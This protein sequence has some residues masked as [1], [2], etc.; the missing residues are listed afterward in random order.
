MLRVVATGRASVA[1]VAAAARPVVRQ[2]PLFSGR[3]GAGYGARFIVS[4]AA[5]VGSFACEGPGSTRASSSRG[6]ASQAAAND[7]S[8]ED[9][10]FQAAAAALAQF[11]NKLDAE[12]TGQVPFSVLEVGLDTLS[13]R[14]PG[15]HTV[16]VALRQRLA[17]HEGASVARAEWDS[18][19]SE[20]LL[21]RGQLPSSLRVDASVAGAVPPSPSSEVVG[22]QRTWSV[23]LPDLRRAVENLDQDKVL[24][25]VKQRELFGNSLTLADL[26]VSSRWNAAGEDIAAEEGQPLTR[27]FVERE[28]RRLLL[29]FFKNMDL[30]AD[31]WVPHGD[32]EAGL[33]ALFSRAPSYFELTS[34]LLQAIGGDVDQGVHADEWVRACDIAVE[35]ILNTLPTDWET[36]VSDMMQELEKAI[37]ALDQTRVRRKAKRRMILGRSLDVPS[38]GEEEFPKQRIE[39]VSSQQL[40]GAG[41][42]RFESCLEGYS[43]VDATLGSGAFARVFLV[44]NEKTGD[45]QA[46]KRIDRQAMQK[47]CGLSKEDVLTRIEHEFRHLQHTDHPHIIKLLEFG[48]DSRYSYFVMEAANGGDLAKVADHAYG[49]VQHKKPKPS[50]GAEA[51]PA[52]PPRKLSEA[53]VAL[54]LEQTVYALHDLHKEGRIHK[55]LK[56]EN[57]MLRTRELPPHVVL[58]DLGFMEMLPEETGERLMPAGTPHTMAP[59]VIE[60][61]LGQRPSFDERCDIYSLGVVLFELL[62]GRPPYEPAYTGPRGPRQEV[63][64]AG[65]LEVIRS[66]DLET[67]LREAGRS[68]DAVDLVKQ[69]CNIDPNQRPTALECLRHSWLVKQGER[70]R[71]RSSASSSDVPNLDLDAASSARR[72]AIRVQ[73]QTFARR[74]A[75]QRAAAYQLAAQMPVGRLR[76]AKG[77]L[78][79]VEQRIGLHIERED[80]ARAL[81]ETLGIDEACARYVAAQLDAE[82][83]VP[84]D[85]ATFA[86]DCAELCGKREA[87][88]LGHVARALDVAGD[89]GLSFGEV[90]GVL[91]RLRGGRLKRGDLAEWLRPALVA[92]DTF[93]G[94]PPRPPARGDEGGRLTR[95]A[96]ERHFGIVSAAPNGAASPGDQPALA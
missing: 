52:E 56:L 57:L 11:F 44:K 30:N 48:Q 43:F 61:Y 29:R 14:L 16:A 22:V 45:L 6:T 40:Q 13:S 23:L 95:E 2:A 19:C 25:R 91:E 94:S 79:F 38:L 70:R 18:A 92:E 63:D 51:A 87:S 34:M 17:V 73:V 86:A 80:L 8:A 71:S 90:L 10:A 50:P 27:E 37:D 1:V 31:S 58:I 41:L 35:E 33:D 84:E 42:R 62:F 21:A 55:D 72:Q 64:Y 78:A 36:T 96:L 54:V 59:E 4:P 82:D 69:M 81:E 85:F 9:A 76:S 83:A 68:S 26:T 7:G 47:A 32:L 15:Y 93:P 65:T 53:Y 88:L 28:H 67:P 66:L 77:L 49:R 12:G 74:S 75:L 60:T 89:R 20:V 5:D 46:M 3:R 24:R 39:G